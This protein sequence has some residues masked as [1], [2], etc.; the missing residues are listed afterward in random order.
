[1]LRSGSQRTDSRL[2][3][4]SPC[5]RVP[6]RSPCVALFRTANLISRLK[7]FLFNRSVSVLAKAKPTWRRAGRGRGCRLQSP[8]RATLPP[9][10]TQ[11][12]RH[13]CLLVRLQSIPDL[14]AGGGG[15]G[16]GARRTDG[17][18]VLGSR[19][20]VTSPFK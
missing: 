6:R 8:C 19:T 10:W 7:S 20:L 18:A 17:K 9:S 1:V 14:G 11:H 16:G 3:P 15:A 4:C 2:I 5:T 13:V 12:P